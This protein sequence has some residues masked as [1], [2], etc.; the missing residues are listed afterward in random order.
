MGAGTRIALAC[1]TAPRSPLRAEERSSRIALAERRVL[2]RALEGDCAR[3]VAYGRAAD[4]A[5]TTA[6]S[7]ATEISR[8]TSTMSRFAFHTRS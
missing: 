8:T 1:A 5:L 3:L 2:E 6:A 7:V 4:A